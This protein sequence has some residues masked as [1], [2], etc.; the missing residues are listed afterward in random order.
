MKIFDQAIGAMY[1]WSIVLLLLLDIYSSYTLGQFPF[2]LI[3]AVLVASIAEIAFTSYHLKHN[4]KIP[5]SGI[6]TGM[7]IGSVAPISVQ[8]VAIAIACI[9]AISSKFLI[10]IKGSNIFNPAA[11]GMLVGLGI[12]SIGDEWWAASNVNLYSIAIPLA[13]IL[14]ISAYQAKR[15]ITAFSFI[16]VATLVGVIL[17]RHINIASLGFALLSVNYFFAFLML[18][19]PKTSPTKNMAQALYG[20]GIAIIYSILAISGVSYSYFVALLF[21]NAAYAIYRRRGHRLI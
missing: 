11:L 6:I 14:V 12:F 8:P 13:I 16:V 5:F 9:L 19:E 17:S 20:V 21:G 7:I 1:I 3:L 4:L 15:L 10:K 18:T 2:G